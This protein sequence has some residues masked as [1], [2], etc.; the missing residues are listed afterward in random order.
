VIGNLGERREIH[1][2]ESGIAITAVIVSIEQC[3]PD[4]KLYFSSVQANCTRRE[5]VGCVAS[6]GTEIKMTNGAVCVIDSEPILQKV[7]R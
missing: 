4:V 2:S 3:R 1:E 5:R 7:V 6:Q